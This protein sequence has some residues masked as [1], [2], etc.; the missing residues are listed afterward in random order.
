MPDKKSQRGL[1]LVEMTVAVGLSAV[2]A[3]LATP[4]L[5]GVL[6]LRRL[7]GAAT[8]LAADLQFARSEALARN[9]P[10]RLSWN[11]AERCYLVHTGAAADCSCF[12]AAAP[13]CSNGAR[14][15]RH[16]AWN[17]DHRLALHSN[18]TSILF[19]PRHG[20]ATPSATLR[21]VA[22]DGRA[23]HHVVNVMGRLRSCTP[24]AAVPGYRAC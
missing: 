16:A 6:D 8:A 5:R 11:A 20:T 1:S 17:A 7:D 13:V 23:I 18:T 10:V 24:L 22:D 3:G 14:A 19:D 15:I 9:R 2:I 4:N 21:V 12:A